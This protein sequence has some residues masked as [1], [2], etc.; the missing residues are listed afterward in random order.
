MKLYF[1]VK[2]SEVYQI[3]DCSDIC[4][5]EYSHYFTKQMSN[6]A[7]DNSQITTAHF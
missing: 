2:E 5:E 4:N 3:R 1:H 7:Q 6:R